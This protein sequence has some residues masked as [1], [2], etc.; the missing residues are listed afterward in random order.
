MIM[1]KIHNLRKRFG[2]T[3][4][5]DN[6]SADILKN[7]IVGF[8]GPNGSGKT[9]VTNLLT[10]IVPIDQGKIYI[11]GI[12]VLDKNKLINNYS[13]GISRTYQATRVFDQ[14][15]VLDNVLIVLNKRNVFNSFF[16]TKNLFDSNKIEEILRKIRLWDKRNCLA[17]ELSY[18]QR[19]LL[20]FA[21]VLAIDAK[22]C[23]FD[24]PF[25]GLFPEMRST[26]SELI[27]NLKAGGKTIILIEHDMDQIIKLADYIMVMSAGKLIAKGNPSEVLT[28]NDILDIYL[29]RELYEK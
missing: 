1:I 7:T 8:V 29:G 9:T 10:G 15:S 16:E 3:N 2:R 25:A 13:F 28:R 27:V 19:K 20:E 23:I 18:G 24:E 12:E 17:S 6:F 22:I 11:D 5:V 4:A 21:R 26:I 14:M